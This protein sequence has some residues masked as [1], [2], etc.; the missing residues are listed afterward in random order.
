MT[1]I[2][3]RE[4]RQNASDLVRRA[5]AGERMTITVSGRAAAELGPVR[6]QSWLS[7]DAIADVFVGDAD[8]SWDADRDLLDHGVRDPWAAR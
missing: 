8:P 2:G 7:W 1:D 5:E 3:L 4:V 6:A